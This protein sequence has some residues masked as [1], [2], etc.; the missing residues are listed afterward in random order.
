M[1]KQ[2]ELLI[3]DSNPP[4]RDGMRKLFEDEG[5]ICS[6]ADTQQLAK[7]LATKKFF[8]CALIDLDVGG[9]GGGLDLLRY[10]AEHS[11]QTK[12]VM[13]TGRRSFEGAVQALR[14]D[15]IDVV[16]KQPSAVSQLKSAVSKACDQYHLQSGQSNSLLTEA[17]DVLDDA[18]RVMLSMAQH[19]YHD[20]SVVASANFKPRILFGEGEQQTVQEL[21]QLVQSKDWEIDAAMS[22]GGA[23]D[24]ASNAPFDLAVIRQELPDLKGS[25]VLKS[26]QR[27][28]AECAGLLYTTPGKHGVVSRFE[29]AKATKD[30]KPL[31]DVAAL[32]AAVESVVEEL[33]RTQRDRRVIQAFRADNQDFFRRF[34]ELKMRIDRLTD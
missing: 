19:V 21:A 30:E 13:V 5:Y 20:V 18:F 33:S 4:H 32:I 15:A 31:A 16:F 34:A 8:P 26:I 24:K 11:K 14:A 3:V 1:A 2:D 12:C 9:S 29:A 25:I 17:H 6:T 10:I 7:N 23:L 22:G 28:R 27:E